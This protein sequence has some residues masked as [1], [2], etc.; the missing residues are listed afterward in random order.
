MH[1][2]TVNGLI[3]KFLKYPSDN[4]LN[5]IKNILLFNEAHLEVKLVEFAR[6]AIRTAILVTKTGGDLEIAV[7]ARYH[8]QLLELLGCLRQRVEFSRLQP[9]WHEEITRALGRGGC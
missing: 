9:C 8:N 3:R 2:L 7:K 5:S 6:T 4:R 1:K